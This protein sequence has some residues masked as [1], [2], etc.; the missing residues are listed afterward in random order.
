VDDR[1]FRALFDE[2]DWQALRL[3]VA[4]VCRDARA[5]N[6]RDPQGWQ[7]IAHTLRRV[8]THAASLEVG[9]D[10]ALRLL[11]DFSDEPMC[12][13]VVGRAQSVVAEVSEPAL[14]A[15]TERAASLVDQ[16]APDQAFR[17]RATLILVS[18]LAC[19]TIDGPEAGPWLADALRRF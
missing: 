15:M 4:L 1:D 2:A 8:G 11:V 18:M 5:P 3:S 14:Q 9:H 13:A 6:A 17:F 10:L 19:G 12:L 7:R 16:A